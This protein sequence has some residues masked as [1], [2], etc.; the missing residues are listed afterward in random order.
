MPFDIDRAASARS[1]DSAVIEAPFTALMAAS[2]IDQKILGCIAKSVGMF[3]SIL[4]SSLFQLL[5]LSLQLSEKLYQLRGQGPHAL[6][7]MQ[8]ADLR[9]SAVWLS[10][11][12]LSILAGTTLPRC[13]T[14]YIEPRCLVM[15][16]KLRASFNHVYCLFNND[17]PVNQLEPA[18]KQDY[19][20]ART[21][22]ER[23]SARGA[24][25]TK[26][27]ADKVTGRYKSTYGSS[28]IPSEPTAPMPPPSYAIPPAP[29]SSYVSE[30]S[31]PC[32]LGTHSAKGCRCESIN[33]VPRTSNYFQAASSLA[34]QYLP[35]SDPLRLS[36]CLEHCVFMD[37]CARNAAAASERARAALHDV[38]S[39][40]EGMSDGD[41]HDAA[42]LVQAL[43]IYG[44]SGNRT[45]R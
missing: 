45:G 16:A 43:T 3:D 11:E 12:G 13:Q 9:R 14:D 1:G 17:P 35:G 2:H 32:L 34:A 26:S 22:A 18:R 33:Y 38:Y 29:T 30:Q 5:G 27:A 23:F 24:G 6:S 39:A 8:A 28:P 41:F 10:Q 15:V 25:G 40:S 7:S 19:M 21:Y 44:D 4:S 37:T 20:P 36:I 42:S 31:K